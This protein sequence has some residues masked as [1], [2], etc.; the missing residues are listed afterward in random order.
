VAEYL[1]ASRKAYTARVRLGEETDTYDADG[2]VV[3]RAPVTVSRTDVEEALSQ[4]RGTIEQTPPMHS[5]IKRD[6]VPLYRLARKGIVVT[7]RPRRVDV[8]RLT[9]NKWDPPDLGLDL[10]CA[11]GTYVRSLAHDIGQA[12]GCGAH[13]TA[14]TRRASGSFR[15]EESTTMEEFESSVGAGRWHKLLQPLDAALKA[16]PAVQLGLEEAVRLCHGQEARAALPFEVLLEE[17]GSRHAPRALVRVYGPGGEVLA[18]ANLDR[19]TGTLHPHKV[20][21]PPEALQCA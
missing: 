21:Y 14:L 16:F 20:F 18:I 15:L 3:G 11:A 13:L 6:G 10:E 9:L 4:F 17:A 1:L 12:L 7:R 19:E 2:V 8:F 5:A